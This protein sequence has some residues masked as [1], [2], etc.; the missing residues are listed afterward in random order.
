MTDEGQTH[1]GLERSSAWKRGGRPKYSY[2]SQPLS[3]SRD[4]G[5]IVVTSRLTG[6]FPG[7][8][9]DLRYAFRLERGKIASLEI[10]PVSLDLQLTGRR[11]LVTG[12]TQ[13]HRRRCRRAAARARRD[14]SSPPRARCRTGRAKAFAYVAA[15]LATA[16][17]CA[18]RR[19][20]RAGACS[21][22]STSSS[23][24]SAARARRQAASPCSTMRN[25]WLRSNL[26]LHA[27]GPARSRTAAA[28][29]RATVWRHHPRDVDPA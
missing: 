13:G 23:M 11:V 16:E 12:G 8:P 7:S 10:T 18:R 22:A 19:Q 20:G 3:Q 14:R 9:V 24:S 26:N 4:G 21:A 25:G 2:T 29:D 27:G 15:D 17:G 5:T 28:D 6:N 1:A